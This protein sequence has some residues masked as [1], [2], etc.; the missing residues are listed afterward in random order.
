[1]Q[2]NSRL[3]LDK[4]RIIFKPKTE[5]QGRLFSKWG[6]CFSENVF[7]TTHTISF[8]HIFWIVEQK[9]HL[10]QLDL[11]ELLC[12]IHEEVNQIRCLTEEHRRDIGD[13]PFTMPA[14]PGYS[15]QAF[16]RAPICVLL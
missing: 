2:D 8:S 9:R 6:S 1:M 5:K 16:S 12:L 10:F 3:L 14:W 15:P 7:S 13:G 11:L 4:G